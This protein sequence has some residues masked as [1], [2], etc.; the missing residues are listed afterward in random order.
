[1]ISVCMLF[2]RVPLGLCV[3]DLDGRQRP[4][5]G[6]FV[7]GRRQKREVGRMPTARDHLVA[8]L[9]HHHRR[10]RH[11]EV[12]LQIGEHQFVV[13]A[14]GQQIVGG[15]RETDRAVCGLSR[16][17]NVYATDTT[18]FFPSDIPHIRCVRLEALRRSIAANVVQNA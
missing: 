1:M 10:Q 7:S 4:Q 9:R 11:G 12:A 18:Q 13:V 15:W 6:R 3:F 16:N 5:R 8:V 2:D 17:C 14:G